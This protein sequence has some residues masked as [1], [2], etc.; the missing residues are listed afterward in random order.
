MTGFGAQS[1]GSD[2]CGLGR[3]RVPE[4]IREYDLIQAGFSFQSQADCGF[5]IQ[6]IPGPLN[7][8]FVSSL[9]NIRQ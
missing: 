7:G 1:F 4:I 5:P 3:K 8:R 9:S 6:G 2:T